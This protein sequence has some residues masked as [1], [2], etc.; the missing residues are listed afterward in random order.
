ML[1]SI[2][3][4]SSSLLVLVSINI[5]HGVQYRGFC[6]TQLLLF[7]PFFFICRAHALHFWGFQSISLGE[8]STAQQLFWE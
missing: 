8:Q 1:N 7:T 2:S 5:Y 6:L 3:V 4:S